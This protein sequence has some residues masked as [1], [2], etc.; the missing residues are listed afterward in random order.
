MDVKARLPAARTISLATTFRTLP[1]NSSILCL[2][3]TSEKSSNDSRI[4]NVD[5]E[6]LEGEMVAQHG[7]DAMTR[8]SV[9]DEKYPPF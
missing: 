7:A 9:I 4:E 6:W 1:K 3:P 5:L 2:Y 8:S